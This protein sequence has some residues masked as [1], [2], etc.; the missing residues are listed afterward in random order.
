MTRQSKFPV[1][2][3]V[4]AAGFAWAWTVLSL[5]FL[6]NVFERSVPPL[7]ATR[8]ALSLPGLF[9]A[10]TMEVLGPQLGHTSSFYA[11]N[12]VVLLVAGWVG[13]AAATVIRRRA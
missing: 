7:D 5:M 11:A 10:R 13:A 8:V 4:V 12:L 1:Q 9:V 3:A 2:F 6:T